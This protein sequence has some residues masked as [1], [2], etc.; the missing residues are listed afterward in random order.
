[1]QEPMTL[2]VGKQAL[3]QCSLT[4]TLPME[5]IWHKDNIAISSEGN[6]VM[7]SD[8]NKCSLLIKS[9]QMTDQGVYL[10]KASN[11]VGT[12]TFTTNLKVINKPSFVKLIEAVSIAVNDLLRLECQVDDDTGVTV[13]WTRDGKKV[14]QSMDCKLSFEDKVAVLEI[15]K[16]KIKDSG[17]STCEAVVTVQDQII[18]PS[19]TR[20]LKQIEGI[21]GSFA[22][23]ECLVSGSLPITIQWFKD[24]SEVLSGERQK[25]TF[26]ENVAFLEISDLDSKDCGNYTCIAKNKAGTVQ[27]SAVLFVKEPPSILENPESLKVLPGSKGTATFIAKVGGDPIPSVKWMKGKW[28]QLTNGGRISIEQKGEVSKLEIRE[29]TKSDSGQYRC[30]ASNK[31]GEIEASADIVRPDKGVYSLTLENDIASVSGEVEVNV[32]GNEGNTKIDTDSFS[33]VLNINECTRNHTGNYLLTVS[34]PA[35]TK[36]VALNVTVLDVPAAP[37]GPVNILEVSPDAMMIEWRPPKDDG[38]SP[39]TNYIVEKRESNKE[40]WG[41]VSSGSLATQLNITRLQKGTEYVVRIRAENKMGIGAPLESKPTVAEHTFMPPSP[42]GKPQTSDISEDAVTVG[43]T[44]PLADGGSPIHGYILERRHK[45]G[46]WIRVNKTP[47]KDLRFRVLGLFEGNEYEF[48]VFAE[49]IA[50]YSGPSPISDPCIPCRPITYVITATNSAGTFTAYANVNVLDIPGPVRNLRVT[51]IGPDKCKVV[52]DGPEDDGGCE[53]DSYILEKCETRRMV[54]ST[55]SAFVVT[56]YCN[57][58]RLVEGNE[59]IFRVRAENKMG[60]G[61]ALETRPVTVRTQFSKPGPP[62]APDVTKVKITMKYFE[63]KPFGYLLNQI[64]VQ[65]LS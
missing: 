51:G 62:E 48:R 31:H 17:N 53:V 60:T 10:C 50:G 20:K 12:A 41:G 1:C 25:Y 13:T 15:P 5:I 32:I 56:P 6:Y 37:I 29:V 21:K 54:W 55:Y 24:D 3:F 19:F 64:I 4:G 40:T 49:N 23:M 18:P 52:W 8:K 65:H 61:P 30:V 11:S 38:G 33:T 34:N 39:V 28:R 43:W 58:T 9:L 27:C 36:T 44:M 45:G 22:H 16:S 42:P 2:F 14:H 35:G 26:F 46:K 63:L 47:H 57:V 7:K 59:Y